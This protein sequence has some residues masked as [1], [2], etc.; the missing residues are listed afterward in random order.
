MQSYRPHPFLMNPGLP[1]R[2]VGSDPGHTRRD[3]APLEL[4][5]RGAPAAGPPLTRPRAG[6]G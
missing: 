3:R 5:P 1:T 2:R 6:Y 4:P